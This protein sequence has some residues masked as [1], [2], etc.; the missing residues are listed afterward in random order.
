MIAV[1]QPKYFFWL[2][3]ISVV[4]IFTFVTTQ[5]DLPLALG[6]SVYQPSV[7][8]DSISPKDLKKQLDQEFLENIR[9]AGEPT[10]DSRTPTQPAV[11]TEK[12]YEEPGTPAMPDVEE[13]FSGF[14][15]GAQ[16][17]GVSET[18]LRC[19]PV[20]NGLKT[21]F[22]AKSN[23]DSQECTKATCAYYVIDLAD[24]NWVK[25]IGDFTDVSAPDK[26]IVREFE[27]ITENDQTLLKIVTRGDGTNLDRYQIYSLQTGTTNPDRILESGYLD[28]NNNNSPAKERFYDW[29]NHGLKIYDS[30]GAVTS[31]INYGMGVIINNLNDLTNIVFADTPNTGNPIK[32]M[33]DYWYQSFEQRALHQ[34]AGCLAM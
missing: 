17:F 30:S 4:V 10:Q 5:I 24:N 13:P 3:A 15:Q 1:Q 28:P 14:M 33:Q 21:C 25:E 34:E 27:R 32:S 12:A 26:L 19:D 8:Q 2:R 18:S 23:Q 9:F 6:Y 20:V 11:P 31:G 16:P 22:F 29:E 7:A